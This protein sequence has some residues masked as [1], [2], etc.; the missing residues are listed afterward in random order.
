LPDLALVAEL[1][2]YCFLNFIHS[3]ITLEPTANP[4]SKFAKA[5]DGA[6]RPSGIYRFT[7]FA[8]RWGMRHVR[9][10]AA[11]CKNQKLLAALICAAKLCGGE[12]LH[13]LNRS[14]HG[15]ITILAIGST[16]LWTPKKP[17]ADQCDWCDRA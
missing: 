7:D 13:G 2:G 10:A 4:T 11:I 12:F 14:E 1:R 8:K 6:N 16:R 9:K 15:S 5:G 17:A 3:R